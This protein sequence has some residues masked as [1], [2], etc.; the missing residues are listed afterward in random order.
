MPWWLVG[1]CCSGHGAAAEVKAIV[2]HK[3]FPLVSWCLQKVNPNAFSTNNFGFT[4]C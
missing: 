3:N 2:F 4:F 1:A